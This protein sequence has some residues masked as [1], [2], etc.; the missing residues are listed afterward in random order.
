[1]PRAWSEASTTPS[2]MILEDVTI[3]RP[4]YLSLTR[5]R[6]EVTMPCI[7]LWGGAGETKDPIR[8]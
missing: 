1:M 7:N 5:R 2:P 8:A 3:G 4:V 6:T